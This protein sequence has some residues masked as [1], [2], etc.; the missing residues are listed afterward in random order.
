[1]LQCL[2]GDTGLAY[3]IGSLGVITPLAPSQRRSTNLKSGWLFPSP[4]T[5]RSLSSN[6]IWRIVTHVH[7]TLGVTTNVH[8]YRKAFTSKLIDSGLNLLEVKAYTRHKDTSTLQVYY[9]RFDIKRTLPTYY[10]T[11]NT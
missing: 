1:M 4:R 7:R 9:D 3:A 11:S 10:E 2:P 5:E 8:G 6:M